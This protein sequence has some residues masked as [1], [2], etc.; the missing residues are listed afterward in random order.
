MKKITLTDFE[1][2]LI[3]QSLENFNK[4]V[5]NNEHYNG[6][7]PMFG[8]SSITPKEFVLKRIAEMYDKINNAE[9]IK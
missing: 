4:F 7:T 9:K 3:K 6:T 5:E 2:V 1:I 8:E